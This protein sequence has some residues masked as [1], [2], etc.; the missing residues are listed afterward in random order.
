MDMILNVSP[1][2]IA[3]TSSFLLAF[4][5]CLGTA[6]FTPVLGGIEVARPTRVVFALALAFLVYPAI[7]P[8]LSFEINW[9]F[10]LGLFLTIRGCALKEFVVGCALGL[11]LRLFFEGVG[12]AGEIIAKV[13][14]VSI[15][16]SF[17]PSLGT[18]VSAL[19]RFCF[20]ISFIVFILTGGC[21]QFF[22]GYLRSFVEIPLGAPLG[23]ESIVD[24]FLATLN[25]GIALAIK[26]AAPVVFSTLS[27]Y[28]VI[29]FIGRAFPQF[30]MTVVA[31]SCNS[32]LTLT[33]LS[34]SIGIC[35]RVF[36]DDLTKVMDVIFERF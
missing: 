26:L 13:G 14:G 16:D 27:I 4:F 36:Q 25:S 29:G 19:S 30:N 24:L 7:N 10:D 8:V 12:L 6:L 21:E 15:A 9:G 35:C 3:T 32:L 1:W 23:M 34:L 31:F 28:V 5:R 11:T 17:D 20:W 2:I 33:V 22:V 18:D